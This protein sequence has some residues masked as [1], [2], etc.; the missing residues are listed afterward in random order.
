M[1]DLAAVANSTTRSGVLSTS[2]RDRPTRRSRSNIGHQPDL[3]TWFS[4]PSTGGLRTAQESQSGMNSDSILALLCWGFR[5]EM[6]EY[7]SK[8]YRV[9][10]LLYD[11]KPGAVWVSELAIAVDFVYNNE[12]FV[13]MGCFRHLLCKRLSI[14]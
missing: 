14:I 3:H 4:G 10:P 12:R 6:V 7:G 11:R 8:V 2:R 1:E 5:N 13:V 9:D